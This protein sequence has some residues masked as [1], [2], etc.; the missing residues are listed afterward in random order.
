MADTK[1]WSFNITNVGMS[2]NLNEEAEEAKSFGG[3]V[4]G[5]KCGH[6]KL[7]TRGHWR[8]AEDSK[9]KEL[10]AQYGPQN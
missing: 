3:F 9:L 7:C 2:L 10:V 6:I 8:P 4:S 1:P 5:N